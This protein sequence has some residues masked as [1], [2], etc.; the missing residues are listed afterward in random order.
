M[1]PDDIEDIDMQISSCIF[2][3]H[4]ELDLTNYGYRQ[5]PESIRP[6]VITVMAEGFINNSGPINFIWSLGENIGVIP[7][8]SD[9]YGEIGAHELQKI[10][11]DLDQLLEPYYDQIVLYEEK[12]RPE[13]T[14]FMLES[15]FSSK[16]DVL[17]S[18]FVNLYKSSPIHRVRY[19]GGIDPDILCKDI[20]VD[21]V[22]LLPEIYE[23]CSNYGM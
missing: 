11:S 9:A 1:N 13:Y 14:T 7:D 23:A 21:F 8:I 16:M 22:E 2:E 3:V 17:V 18:E 20:S 5:S 12:Q 4:S 10:F 15:T 19:V 6:I